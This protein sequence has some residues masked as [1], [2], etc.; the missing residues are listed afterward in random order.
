MQLLLSLKLDSRYPFV[1][2]SIHTNPTV[3]SPKFFRG[4][5]S[6]VETTPKALLLFTGS[7]LENF[8][9]YSVLKRSHCCSLD[10]DECKIDLAQCGENANCTNTIGSFQCTCKPGFAGS[11]NECT[12]EYF[13]HMRSYSST[14][15]FK[16]L[17][18]LLLLLAVN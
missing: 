10:V 1:T 5:V 11:D 13:Q 12:G 7:A 4:I 3:Q 2:M 16:L 17:R 9:V 8:A 15:L 6:T 18:L 14:L